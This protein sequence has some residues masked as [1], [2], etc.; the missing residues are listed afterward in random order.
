MPVEVA[1]LFKEASF[2]AGDQPSATVP[3]FVRGTQEHIEAYQAIESASSRWID[4][5]GSGLILTPRQS[6]RVEPLGIDTWRGVVTYGT[7][8]TTTSQSESPDRLETAFAFQTRQVKVTQALK[9]VATF[10]AFPAN[11]NFHDIIGVTTEGIEGT[12]IDVAELS[13][14]KEIDRAHSLVTTAWINDLAYTINEA[15][16]NSV[17]F[18]GFQA[19]EVRIVAANGSRQGSGSWRI[20][21]NFLISRNRTNI[22]IGSGLSDGSLPQYTILEKKGWH[23][24]DTY[25]LRK[26]DQTLK[27]VVERPRMTRVLQV[28]GESNLAAVLGFAA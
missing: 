25:Y 16:V 18:I 26:Y 4:L 24:L 14:T 7:R 5:F 1:A 11:P 22:P 17:P 23:L 27:I 8:T 2:D 12:E 3:Y 19:G 13:V 9:T 20:A 28:Y 21:Y 6:I 15:P 10:S